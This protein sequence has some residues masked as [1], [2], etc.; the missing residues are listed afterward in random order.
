MSTIKLSERVR[1]GSECAPWVHAE[2]VKLESSV[3]DLYAAPQL[4]V[5]P[6][7]LS[8]IRELA[9]YAEG[10]KSPRMVLASRAAFAWL[11]GAQPAEQMQGR[12]Y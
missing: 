1:P 8:D 12:M 7:L 9:A 6:S 10:S 2:I 3:I 4:A 11:E 5:S